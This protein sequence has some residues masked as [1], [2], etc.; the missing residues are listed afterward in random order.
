M[1]GRELIGSDAEKNEERDSLNAEEGCTESS[2]AAK[3]SERKIPS[4]GRKVSKQKQGS[5]VERDV[6]EE[7]EALEEDRASNGMILSKNNSK[8]RFSLISSLRKIDD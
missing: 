1:D 4:D 8:L 3:N 2:I 7:L 5:L 6:G